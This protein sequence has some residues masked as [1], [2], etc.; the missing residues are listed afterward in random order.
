MTVLITLTTA[1]LDVETFNLYSNVDGYISTFN[2]NI[3]KDDLLAG[4]N[5]NTVPDY[6]SIIRI[7]ANEGLCNNYIDVVVAPIIDFV[8]DYSCSAGSGIISV[9]S[10]IGGLGDLEIGNNFFSTEEDALNNTEWL[11]SLSLSINTGETSGTFYMVVKDSLDNKRV[12]S[13]TFTCPVVTTTT[14]TTL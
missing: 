10:L 3:P 6:T 2:S 12:K 14:T 8:I 5:C 1:G 4:Y 11:P 9:S 13:V 7:K